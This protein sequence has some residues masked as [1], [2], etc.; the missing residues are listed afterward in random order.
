MCLS[1]SGRLR[2]R[3]SQL[4]GLSPDSSYREW[5][6]MIQKT[7]QG[8]KRRDLILFL[9]EKRWSS[10]RQGIATSV[11]PRASPDLHFSMFA[12]VFWVGFLIYCMDVQP[13][14]YWVTSNSVRSLSPSRRIFS[15]ASPF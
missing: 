6:G 4:K 5:G 15:Q 11:A 7:I 13:S 14:N 2:L 3:R 1:V 12:Q 10:G 8:L 9:R